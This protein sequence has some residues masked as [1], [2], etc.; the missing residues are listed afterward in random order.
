MLGSGGLLGRRLLMSKSFSDW[1]VISHGRDNGMQVSADLFSAL[2]THKMLS[3]VKP[4]IVINLAGLTNVDECEE[5][6]HKSYLGNVKT[7]ENV[8]SWIKCVDYH[9]RLIHIS[10]DQVYDGLGPHK[11]DN[12]CLKNYYAFSKYAGELVAGSVDSI[13]LRTNFFGKTATSKRSSFTDWLYSSLSNRTHIKLFDDVMFSPLSMETL[14]KLI[15]LVLRSNLS[16]V[17]NLGAREGL[18]K[19]EFAYSFANAIETNSSLMTTCSV[20]DVNFVKAYRP[21]DMRMNVSRF[22]SAMG[23]LL[24]TLQEEIKSVAREYKN[25]N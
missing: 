4:D 15:S 11:E 21:K 6:P 1:E 18:S 10:T 8:T 20:S 25:E 12:I 7:L 16:G 13:I 2:S 19:A 3:N 5:F 24:P 22:E 23:I 14:C 17:Y 9:V